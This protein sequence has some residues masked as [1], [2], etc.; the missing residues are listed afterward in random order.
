MPSP[1]TQAASRTL[2]FDVL[3]AALQLVPQADLRRAAAVSRAYRDAA[4]HAG[5]YIH[6]SV[7]WNDNLQSVFEQIK[8]FMEVALYTATN[9]GR[10]SFELAFDGYIPE[11]PEEK[12]MIYESRKS[13]FATLC[14][15]LA[16]SM[17]FLV[18]LRLALPDY[19]RNDMDAVLRRPAP[20]LRAFEIH[21]FGMQGMLREEPLVP[22]KSD[23]FS[24]EAPKLRSL[25]LSYVPLP[26]EPLAVLSRVTHVHLDFEDVFPEIDLPRHFPALDSLHIEY[27]REAAS[28]PAPGCIL[29][30]LQLTTLTIDTMDRTV[31]LPF[32]S[33]A[34]DMTSIPVVKLVQDADTE[35]GC[36]WA[37][38]LAEKD[39]TELHG[40]ISGSGT[41]A[42]AAEEDVDVVIALPRAGWRREFRV[43]EWTLREP[44]ALLRCGGAGLVSLRIENKF[45]PGL[46]ESGAALPVLRALRVDLRARGRYAAMVWPAAW[47]VALG[48]DDGGEADGVYL[49]PCPR[50]E[51]MSIVAPGT[52]PMRIEGKEV[53]ELAEA[54]GQADRRA[55]E[56]ARLVLRGVVFKSPVNLAKAFSSVGP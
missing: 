17:R 35:D 18:F 4:K 41:A 48:S 54:L 25:A 56:R 50:L 47:G 31:M 15:G 3:H 36:D 38:T 11:S 33:E 7:T 14:A 55:G 26:A 39:I 6:R 5:L 37:G 42:D 45:L 1:S 8:T 2:P 29:R 32:I 49:V 46:L 27:L 51:T 30:G 24:G 21:D 40:T 43:R 9:D 19:F 52:T 28:A 16:L 22:L 12:R 53:L 34:L 23:I 10:L 13:F 44:Y 20:H